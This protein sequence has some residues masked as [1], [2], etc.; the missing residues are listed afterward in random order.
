MAT[1]SVRDIVDDVN[2]AVAF[3]HQAR[4]ANMCRAIAATR[5]LG[6]SVD[7]CATISPRRQRASPRPRPNHRGDFALDARQR[8]GA[9]FRSA[10]DLVSLS[11]TVIGPGGHYIS[12]LSAPDFKVFEDGRPPEL[13]FFSRANMALSVSLLLDSSSSMENQ[14]ALAQKAAM[15]CVAKLRPGD[16]A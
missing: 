6:W 12:D 8:Q 1:V 7:I 15:E 14:M 5:L 10:I 9:T 16:V 2:A 13:T 4:K 11:V 3:L